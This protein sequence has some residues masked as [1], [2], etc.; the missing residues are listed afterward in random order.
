MLIGYYPLFWSETERI[1]AYFWIGSTLRYIYSFAI[2]KERVLP[3]TGDVEWFCAAYS[4][5]GNRYSLQRHFTCKHLLPFLF[6]LL[7]WNCC[8]MN[9][10][11]LPKRLLHNMLL[12]RVAA[13]HSGEWALFTY[14]ARWRRLHNFVFCSTVLTEF[15]LDSQVLYGRIPQNS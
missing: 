13:M 6:F 2:R 14:V 1:R 10:S 3:Y 4:W 12:C 5:S 8:C 7:K 15:C 9:V 11:Y